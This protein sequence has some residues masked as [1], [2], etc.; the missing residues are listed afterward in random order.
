MEDFLGADKLEAIENRT[1]KA[2]GEVVKLLGVGSAFVSPA[3]AA[4]EMIESIVW[5][6]KKVLPCCVLLEGEYG[7]NGLFVG[8]PVVLGKNGIE[9]VIEMK[10]NDAEKAGLEK[11]VA[12]VAKVADEVKSMS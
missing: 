12:A 5:D 9:K 1:R 10:L 7:V 4:L 3:W 11:S 8:V 6:K 2:G